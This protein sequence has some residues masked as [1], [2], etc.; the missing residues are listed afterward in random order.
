[1]EALAIAVA[2]REARHLNKSAALVTPDRALARRVAAALGRW[3]LEFDDSGGDALTDTSAGIFARLAAEAAANGLE[4]PT[5]LALLKHPLC[6][7]GGAPAAFKDAIE[8]LELALLRG[9]RPQAGSGGLAHDFA[10]FREELDKASQT[11]KPPRCTAPSRAPGSATTSSI[12]AAA[13]R[14]V[15]EGTRFRSRAWVPRSHTI[16]PNWQDAIA[17]C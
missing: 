4:P 8:V 13:D 12:G 10:R 11:A 15:A 3:N 17:R 1:M 6:R 7:L 9:T 14:A 2:M 16:L 5:L